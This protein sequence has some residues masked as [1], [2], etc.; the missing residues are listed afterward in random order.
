[1]PSLEF[2]RREVLNRGVAPARV[3][4]TFDELEH[5]HLRF[6]LCNFVRS[7]SSHSKVAK[8]L[9][10]SA[11][12]KQSPTDPIEGRTPACRQRSP[13]AMEVYCVPWT[14]FC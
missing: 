2:D 6:G 3:V 12:S 14:P 10:A 7:S 13:K 4:P 1:M 8:K 9:S 5:R 11:L